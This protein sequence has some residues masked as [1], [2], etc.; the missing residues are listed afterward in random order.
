[1]GV[2]PPSP[3]YIR[4]YVYGRHRNYVTIHFARTLNK[5]RALYS[6]HGNISVPT[7]Y[8]YI[9]YMYIYG[10]SYDVINTVSGRLAVLPSLIAVFFVRLA[11][12]VA[13]CCQLLP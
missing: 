6:S 9:K 5:L 4:I 2:P 1:M 8:L 13:F 12:L 3:S 11:Y 10:S 7:I